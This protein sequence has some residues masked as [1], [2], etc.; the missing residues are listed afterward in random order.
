VGIA[1][2]TFFEWLFSPPAMSYDEYQCYY[3]NKG[4]KCE[5]D[6]STYA[7]THY[8]A[9]PITRTVSIHTIRQ[10][11]HLKDGGFYYEREESEIWSDCAIVNA[12]NF[13]CNKSSRMNGKLETEIYEL[14]NG[15]VILCSYCVRFKNVSPFAYL[16][17]TTLRKL[18]YT[19][20]SVDGME[21]VKCP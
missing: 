2:V 7:V 3:G 8:L 16:T 10:G 6:G 11:I 14:A 20:C 13:V 5:G 1:G 21:A 19:H 17:E 12:A 15:K 4:K 18:K 9:N